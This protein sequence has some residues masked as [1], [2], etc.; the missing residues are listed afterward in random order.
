MKCAYFDST[1]PQPTPVLG[2]FDVFDAQNNPDGLEYPNLPAA[3][4]LLQLTDA[5]WVSRMGTPYV[6]NGALVEAPAPTPSHLLAQ[7]QI[8]QI[9]LLSA[10]CATQIYAGFTSSGLGTT[11]TY[12]AK[13]KDQ[14][15][16]TASYAA[17]FDPTNAAN[18]TTPFWCQDSAG[19]W[20]LVPHTA[21]QIQQVG[22]DGKAA[23]LDAITR[24]DQLVAQV[25][26]AT[27][28]AAVQS[29]VW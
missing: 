14:T 11:H 22:R 1:N 7:A 13:D 17:S 19:N 21:A 25:M 2:W 12:P 24:N 10:A 3:S 27:T 15:N 23:I 28:V 16:L 5:E 4:D 9:A 29:T 18:W 26:A 8:A 20:A 6:Q